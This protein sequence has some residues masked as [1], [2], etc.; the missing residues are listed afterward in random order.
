MR[1]REVERSHVQNLYPELAGLLTL[2]LSDRLIVRCGH[3]SVSA[4]KCGHLV[5]TLE[6]RER[7]ELWEQ[8][9]GQLEAAGGAME[10]QEA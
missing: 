5:T 9:L 3:R 2:S 4:L 7:A 10:H 1:G 8:A 6:A